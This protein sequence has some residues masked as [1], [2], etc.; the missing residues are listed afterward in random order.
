MSFKFID[1]KC[2]CGCGEPLGWVSKSTF[3]RIT[4]GCR[5]SGWIRGHH[6]KGSLNNNWKGGMAH[7]SNGYKLIKIPDHPNARKSG[8]ILEHRAIASYLLGRPLL[9]GEVVHHVNHKKLDNSPE[10]LEVTTPSLHRK[11][12]DPNS[13]RRVE[14]RPK[15]CISCGKEFIK[16]TI[17]N[18]KRSKFCSIKCRNSKGETAVRR[19]IP[20]SEELM[21]ISLRGNMPRKEIAKLYGVSE[22]AIKHVYKRN[23]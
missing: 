21:I 16:P 9:F 13:F 12:H 22:T 2:K 7:P 20:L 6:A 17:G 14:K 23:A 3:W 15:R 19:K 11:E 1:Q 10:N 5:N 8:Y 18:H 4:S